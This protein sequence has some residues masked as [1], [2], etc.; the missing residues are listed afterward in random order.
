MILV[1]KI[2]VE[3]A[4]CDAAVAKARA[5]WRAHQSKHEEA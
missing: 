2:L 4:D 5:E 1:G 3:I